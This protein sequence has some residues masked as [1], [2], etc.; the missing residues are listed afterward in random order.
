MT[1]IDWS[2]FEEMLGLL[3]E[4]VADERNDAQEDRERMRFLADLSRDLGHIARRAPELSADDAIAGL[5]NVL[6]SQPGSFAGDPVLT[7]V[8]D[9]IQELERIRSQSAG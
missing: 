1:F 2:D 5:R 9:C 7:H 4:Y 6:A 8:E 3:V